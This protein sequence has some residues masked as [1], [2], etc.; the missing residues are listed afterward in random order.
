VI[1][2][3]A[4]L[5]RAVAKLK[6]PVRID[7][8]LDRRVMAAIEQ[9][10]AP[11]TPEVGDRSVVSWLRRR[12]TIRLSP[13]AGLAAAAALAA[14]MFAGVRFLGPERAAVARTAANDTAAPSAGR[15]DASGAVMQFVLVAPEAASVAVVGDF[16]DWSFSATPL[17]R[18]AGDGV[19]W[20][21]VPLRP[22]RYRYAFVVDGSTWR[23][24]PTVPATEDEFG[25]P[26]SVVTI[27]GA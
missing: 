1:D 22:G 27:G 7:P 9:L 17:E 6:E 25:R 8:D 23:T 19:W 2:D 13:L 14:V 12:R 21:T 24:D 10:P 4:A 3:D 11:V 18:Q 5:A 15:A 16:N 26:N 20:V